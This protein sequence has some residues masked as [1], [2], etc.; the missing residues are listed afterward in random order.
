MVS[1]M[2]GG[3]S[4]ESEGGLLPHPGLRELGGFRGRGVHQGSFALTTDRL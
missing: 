3:E 4:G 2:A 1:D